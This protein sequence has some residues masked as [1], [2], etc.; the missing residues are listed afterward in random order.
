[1]IKQLALCVVA[2]LCCSSPSQS[3]TFFGPGDITCDGYLESSSERKLALDMYV[4]GYVSGHSFISS[5][6]KK[7]DLLKS[8][9]SS[10][11]LLFM[12]SYCRKNKSNTLLNASNDFMI[13][14]SKNP[15]N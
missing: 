10:D 11:A 2:A 5:L 3:Q 4:L 6:V 8:Y 15:G 1:M 9:E 7:N 14:V 12:R 13:Y